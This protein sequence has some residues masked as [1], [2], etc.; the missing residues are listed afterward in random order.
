MA[1]VVVNARIGVYPQERTVG[2]EFHINVSLTIP[3]DDFEEENLD[4]SV[5]YVGIYELIQGVLSQEWLL[6]E[7]VAKRIGEG[8]EKMIHGPKHQISVSVTK[9]S[10]PIPGMQGKATVTWRSIEE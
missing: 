10:V 5:S 4:S 2:N 3:A 6:L 7:T 1:D 9:V 8:L